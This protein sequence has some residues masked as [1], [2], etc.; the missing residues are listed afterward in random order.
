MDCRSRNLRCQPTLRVSTHH[1]L[2]P[3]EGRTNPAPR[4]RHEQA[5]GFSRRSLTPIGQAPGLETGVFRVGDDPAGGPDR[6]GGGGGGTPGRRGGRGRRRREDGVL[7]AGKD[8]DGPGPERLRRETGSQRPGVR[9]RARLGRGLRPEL[10]L[11]PCRRGSC[12]REPPVL[13][14]RRRGLL[15]VRRL[16][17]RRR[18]GLS[19]AHPTPAART[20][21]SRDGIGVRDGSWARKGAASL[22]PRMTRPPRRRPGAGA[23][24]R[25]RGAWTACGSLGGRSGAMNTSS[26]LSS[27]QS[28]P[29]DPP[30]PLIRRSR[31]PRRGPS[32]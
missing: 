2:K 17:R 32:A 27:S 16:L 31:A 21:A 29:L 12:R 14:V 28:M 1:R 26:G 3:A 9:G 7:L 15:D 8:G 4:P 11:G 25:T 13:P 24:R 6:P 23:S 20:R 30:G 22:R 19:F 5:A 18:L 10:A